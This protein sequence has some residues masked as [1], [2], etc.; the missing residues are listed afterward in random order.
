MVDFEEL[1]KLSPEER[2]KKLEE[3]EEKNKKETEEAKKLLE[4]SKIEIQEETKKSLEQPIEEL[5]K[6]NIDSSI[7][8]LEH[9][10]ISEKPEIPQEELERQ[11]TQY[12]LNL[13]RSPMDDIYGRIKSIREAAEERGYIDQNQA[14]ELSNIYG[15]IG[16]KKDDFEEGSYKDTNSQK[17]DNQ[18]NSAKSIINHLM[19]MYK[20]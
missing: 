2:I 4:R 15:A 9:T 7:S 18:T 16:V 3:L 11:Q 6:V 19:G 20:G 13:S 10:A 8:D 12:I 5:R 1:K 14:Y 17:L